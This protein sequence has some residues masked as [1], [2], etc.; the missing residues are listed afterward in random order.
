MVSGAPRRAG[1]SAR[2]SDARRQVLTS[3]CKGIVMLELTVWII[4]ISLIIIGLP[5]VSKSSMRDITL[6]VRRTQ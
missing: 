4:V 2:I 3:S 6:P 1:I 5:G